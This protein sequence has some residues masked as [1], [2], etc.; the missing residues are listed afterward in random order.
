MAFWAFVSFVVAG[1]TTTA[2]FASFVTR[3]GS[4]LMLDGAPFRFAGANC[5]WLGLDENVLNTTTG[6]KIGYPTNFR[7]DD[8]LATAAEMGANVVRAHT[9]GCS[10]GNAALSYEGARGVFNDAAA[11]R[12]DYA[13]A[14]AALHGIRLVVPLTDNYA[15]YH[16]GKHDFADWAGIT[17]EAAKA[18]V[19]PAS[20]KEEEAK[21]CAFYSDSAVMGSFHAY[22]RKLVTR[23]NRY[24]GV[25][26]ADDP[27]ILAWETGN[28]LVGVPPAWTA[29]ISALLK[30][31]LGAKQLVM[32]G[33]DGVRMGMQDGALKLADVD[34]VT[35][36]YYMD[37]DKSAVPKFLTPDAAAA[38]KAQKVF[39]VGEF[40]WNQ[41]N[42]SAFLDSVLVNEA[43][44]GD[45]YWSLFPHGDT[46]GFVSHGDSFT[47]HYPGATAPAAAAAALLRTHAFAMRGISPPPAPSMCPAPL[48]TG[49]AG[50]FI[51]W[52]GAVG[53][54]A[55][56]VERALA[57]AGPWSR[58]CDGCATD[59][60]TPWQDN[61]RATDTTVYYRVQ[62]INLD[63]KAGA[64]SPVFESVP[65]PGPPT[66]PPTPVL[67]PS[68]CSFAPNTDCRGGAGPGAGEAAA[69][70]KEECCSLCQARPNC[71]SSIYQERPA[72]KGKCFFKPSDCTPISKDGVIACK[73]NF[74]GT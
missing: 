36:H 33:R 17:G 61:T 52:R 3:Q 34:V 26:L 2:P 21:K 23:V 9:L 15:Y 58:V 5:Y 64:F 59:L 56:N 10:T 27:T 74:K 71:A 38:R 16:G 31:E 50:R 40:G 67:P 39:T 69:Q 29:N 14:S 13:V 12:M 57:V 66:P 20:V 72:G 44:A 18:C 22:V 45:M 24:T 54:K 51:T 60:D 53:A 43:V 37:L 19:L 68:S 73:P 46:H 32:D 30:R 42:L 65:S 41:G 6:S 47:L 8:A 62:G 1:T 7:I 35:D 63:G 11:E 28:E 4:T 70:T 48:V 49:T 55:Y 25:A